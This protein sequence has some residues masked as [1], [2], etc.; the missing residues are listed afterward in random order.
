MKQEYNYSKSHKV[1]NKN[2]NVE[3]EILIQNLIIYVP[4][5]H[6]AAVAEGLEYSSSAEP[7][8]TSLKL[9]DITYDIALFIAWGPRCN[10]DNTDLCT[11]NSIGISLLL[12][13]K[14]IQQW[15]YDG[16]ESPSTINYEAMQDF[17]INTV[18]KEIEEVRKSGENLDDDEMRDWLSGHRFMPP[19]HPVQTVV[20]NYCKL[21]DIILQIQ[22]EQVN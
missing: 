20:K 5:D 16:D 6:M 14:E 4:Y 18:N 1:A 15:K 9:I 12:H 2:N 13:G 7:Y 11:M 8:F 19:A 21:N 10:K 22:S 3:P 17:I